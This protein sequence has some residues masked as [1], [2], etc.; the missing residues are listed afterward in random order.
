M[1][2]AVSWEVGDRVNHKVGFDLFERLWRRETYLGIGSDADDGKNPLVPTCWNA[3]STMNLRLK[4][5]F[6]L[7]KVILIK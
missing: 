2:Q 4:L 5:T 3:Q 1:C 7:Q 6:G